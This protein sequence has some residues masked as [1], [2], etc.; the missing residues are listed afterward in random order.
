[1]IKYRLKTYHGDDP[2]LDN[3]IKYAV[4]PRPICFASTISKQGQVN[5]SPFSYFNLISHHPAICVFSPVR[6]MRDGSTKHTLNNIREVPEVVIN[7]VDYAMVQQQSLA[8]TEYP[9]GVDE[10]IKSGVTALP[11]ELIAPPRVG[12]SPVQLEC[13]VQNVVSLGDTPGAGSLV[14]AEVLRMHVREDLLDGPD[15]LNQSKLDLVARLGGDWYCRVIEANLFE[16]PKPLRNLGIGVDQLPEDIRLSTV[17]TGNHLAQLANVPR[18]PD[19][20]ATLEDDTSTT[21]DLIHRKAAALLD[22]GDMAG[23]WQVLLLGH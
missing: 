2:M 17:L 4:A 6:R 9:E 20:V 10:F 21:R 15:K 1:M 18:I 23:A 19:R 5:L 13:R 16:V 11:S 12:E 14:L 22:A 8:S 7:I 3:L